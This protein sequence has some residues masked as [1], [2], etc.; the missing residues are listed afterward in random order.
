MEHTQTRFLPLPVYQ[1]LRILVAKDEAKT[2]HIT[3]EMLNGF[4]C[5]MDTAGD[6]VDA[7]SVLPQANFNLLV[8]DHEMPDLNGVKLVK[9]G[10]F[11]GRALPAGTGSTSCP[12]S[13][14]EMTQHE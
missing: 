8:T 1:S 3:A 5:P 4:R 9:I 11:A 10:Q 13:H 6:A 14:F 7:R 12:V 2:W